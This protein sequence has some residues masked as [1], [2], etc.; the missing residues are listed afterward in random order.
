[1][2]ALLALVVA[3]L[4]WRFGS[5]GSHQEDQIPRLANSPSAPQAPPA[6]RPRTQLHKATQ[7]PA[8]R[9]PTLVRLVLTASNGRCWI[10]AH[11]GSAAG[12]QLYAGVL[13]QG[14]RVQLRGR[15]LWIRLGAPSA[16]TATL[17]G[18]EVALPAVTSNVSVT[19]RGIA[20]G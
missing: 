11:R 3:L 13:E 12:E 16:V 9:Q 20:P 5:S 4:A 18:H 19:S 2:V 1:V 6:A 15:R 7:P 8:V 17:N 10:E 14:Q